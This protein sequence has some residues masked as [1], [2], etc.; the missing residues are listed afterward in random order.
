MRQ[1]L[2]TQAPNTCDARNNDNVSYSPSERLGRY[3]NILQPSHNVGSA[4]PRQSSH[5]TPYNFVPYSNSNSNQS[6]V[7]GTEIHDSESDGDSSAISLN[8]IPSIE[9]DPSATFS[10]NTPTTRF[11]RV[12]TRTVQLHNLA[13]GTTLSDITSVVRGGLIVDIY[14]RA[15]D[16]V[17]ALSFLNSSDAH[18][19]YHHVQTNGLYIKYTKVRPFPM[20][21]DILWNCVNDSV[22]A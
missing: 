22:C 5:G 20:N 19:F 9:G 8:G 3:N 14:F 7:D 6:T 4:G 15:R 1:L 10:G 12:A 21:C 11:E 2:S 13:E 17:V 16:N 18:A